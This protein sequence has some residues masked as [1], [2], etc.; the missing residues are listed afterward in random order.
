MHLFYIPTINGKTVTLPEE[1]SKHCI[2]VLRLTTD[3]RI[4]LVN[5]KG[6]F[7][8]CQ[9]TNP[10][11]KQCEVEVIE[12]H[13]DYNIRNF[14]LHIA[15]APTKSM[16]RFEWFLEKATE[17]GVDEITPLLC[18]HSERKTVNL[19]RMERVA[20]SAMKQSVKAYLPKINPI[21]PFEKVVS[22][23][24]EHHKLIA[25]CE[26]FNEPHAKNFIEPLK[27]ILFLVG[28][29]GDFSPQ[30]VEFAL[31]HGF[32][33]VGLGKSRLRTETAGVV[34]CTTANTINNM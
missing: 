27:S 14:R 13:E 8:T 33:V 1:E 21:T 22:T 34:A 15:I 25:Y 6:A 11:P 5:G 26:N 2:R 3:D 18:D 10:H 29:E 7:Y 17:I 32:K 24:N 12:V 30:E 16:D 31:K 9:I 20:I 28:P 23:A 19:D 4:Q